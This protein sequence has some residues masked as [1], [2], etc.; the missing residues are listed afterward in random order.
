LF[1]VRLRSVLAWAVLGSA[2]CTQILGFDQDFY[3][4][5]GG[6]AGDAS[7]ADTGGADTVGRDTSGDGTLL[8]DTGGGDTTRPD[9]TPPDAFGDEPSPSFCARISPKPLFCAD[10]DESPDI[11]SEW[12]Y[13]HQIRG[14]LAS[15][16][17]AWSS[18]PAAMQAQTD[19]VTGSNLSIDTAGYRDFNLTGQTFSGAIDLDL[20]VDQVDSNTGVAVVAQFGLTDGANGLYFLQF[21]ILSNG[22]DPLNCVLNEDYFATSTNGMPT[23]H[24]ISATIP[25][26]RWVHV[27]VSM[28][29]PFAGGAGTASAVIEGGSA[30]TAPITVPVTNFM[31]E[32]IGVGL[33]Y[34]STPSNGWTVLVDNV[35]FNATTN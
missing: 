13:L 32:T 20:R 31:Q 4:V 2:G 1:Y 11:G 7:V 35:V 22:T 6:G 19:V 12:G 3:V 34:A 5:D 29:V 10:F 17:T 24:P 21:V 15:Y 23:S 30:N 27:K 9:A 16:T 33:T 18:A 28:V 25:L 26:N 14:A 8:V